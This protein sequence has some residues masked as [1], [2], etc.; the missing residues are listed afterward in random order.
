MWE[1]IN[2]FLTVFQKNEQL[3]IIILKRWQ[4]NN[5][6]SYSLGPYIFDTSKFETIQIKYQ[7][8][9]AFTG[10]ALAI[11]KN[12]SSLEHLLFSWQSW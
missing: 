3:K 7:I 2:P 4:C 1:L 10:Q 9:K 5:D 6:V 8:P 11:V 12:V